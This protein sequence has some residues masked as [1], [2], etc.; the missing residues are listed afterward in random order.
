MSSNAPK[1][2]V[3]NYDE[4]NQSPDKDKV[5]EIIR[6]L[7]DVDIFILTTQ[8]SPSGTD[9]HIH[10]S[11]KEQIKNNQ[12]LQKYELFSKIDATRKS[13]S[14]FGFFKNLYN[15]R[16]RIWINTETVYK[17]FSPCIE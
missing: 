5:D 7:K 15:V 12:L 10:H 11:I 8:D 14:D 1:V 6:K 4:N 16:T 2:L 17:S 9:S 13:N 3:I